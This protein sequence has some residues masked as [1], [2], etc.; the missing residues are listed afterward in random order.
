MPK[1]EAI[2][3]MWKYPAG[4]GAMVTSPLALYELIAPMAQ[5]R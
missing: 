5:P 2:G 4:R 3:S 1:P